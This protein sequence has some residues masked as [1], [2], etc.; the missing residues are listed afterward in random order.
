MEDDRR[1]INPP[2]ESQRTMK[3][4]IPILFVLFSAGF[5]S[6]VV[7]SVESGGGFEEK[8]PDGGFV[9]HMDVIY[10]HPGKM[11]RM[12]GALGPLQDSAVQATMTILLNKVDDKTTITTTYHVGGYFAGGLKKLA[13]VVDQVITEQFQ[14]LGKRIEGTLVET[15]K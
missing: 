9:R 6:S 7:A 2:N 15:E 4:P 1:L 5:S 8:L 10:C 3:L 11:L 13:P 14:R 12:T